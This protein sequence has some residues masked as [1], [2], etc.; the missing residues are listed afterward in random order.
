MPRREVG[1]LRTPHLLWRG[2]F[3]AVHAPFAS[4]SIHASPLLMHTCARPAGAAGGSA[5]P[6]QQEAGAAAFMA[7][8]R[9]LSLGLPGGSVEQGALPAL[10]QVLRSGAGGGAGLGG[11]YTL[12]HCPSNLN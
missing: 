8:C 11:G 10:L 7:S 6:V 12:C 1:D 9:A 5:G 4:N 3:G 2:H